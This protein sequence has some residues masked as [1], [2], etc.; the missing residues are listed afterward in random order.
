MYQT[1]NQFKKGF[2]H[3]FSIIRNKKEE[4]ARLHRRKQRYGK[5]ILM[6]Y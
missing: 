3:K 5:N 6:N 4:L 2:Q 1:V